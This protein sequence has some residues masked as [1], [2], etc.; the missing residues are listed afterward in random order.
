[1]SSAVAD[2]PRGGPA[3]TALLL[4]VDARGLGGAMLDH[5]LHEQA[6]SFSLLVQRALPDG[7]PLRRVPSSVTPDRLY[8][9]VDLA[10]T[11]STGTLVAERGVLA[12]ADGGVIVV[13]MA[14]RLSVAARTALCEV[15]DYAEVQVARDG[16]GEHHAARICAIVMD[17]SIDDESVHD[18]LRDRLAFVVRMRGSASE[19]LLDDTDELAVASW[20]RQARDAR[21]R[22][23]SVS[24]DD[25]WIAALCE[26]ADAFGI[27]SVRAPL[28][29][30][31]CARAHAALHGR[32]MITEADAEVAAA[33]VLAPRATRLPPPPEEPANDNEQPGEPP[34]SSPPEPPS[35]K[36]G[37]SADAPEP[38]TPPDQQP[39]DADSDESEQNDDA[40]S[41]P[42]SSTDVLREAVTSALPPGMLAQLLEKV[43]GGSMQGRVGAE[44]Q[45]MLRGRPRGSRSGLP[46]GG[47]RLH[48][49][50]TLRAAAPWQR[51]RLKQAAAAALLSATPT[52]KAR[53]RVNIRREDFRIRRYIEKTG[54][55]VLFVVDASG[56]SA[57]NRLAEA[58]GAVEMLLAE[59]YAR[60]DRVSLIAFRGKDTEL[61][62][63][64]TRA[65]ARAKKVLAALPGGG[66]TPLAHAI[67][68]AL[69]QALGAKRAGSAPLVVMLTDGRA[70][71]ARDGTPGRPG[72]ERDALAASARFA[73]QHIPALFVDTSARGEP[74]A[75]RVADAMRARYVLLPA[76]NAKALGGLVRTAMQMAEGSDRA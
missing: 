16:I 65:L 41:P 19:A 18:A 9:G 3:L 69:E 70:N 23:M 53:P 26:T 62:L 73:Q 27:D 76:A 21:H 44:K 40:P 37:E 15:L 28:M 67:E 25:S 49:L 34:P 55:T 54:T 60:R 63:P 1:M 13:P 39:P 64:P 2:L 33:L 75:R 68:A 51:A 42:S 30:L 35:A 43:S 20:E 61:L 46:R 29:A 57:L 50:E 72:A 4:A 48:L 66:G 36:D 5:P 14:E 38:P 12:A 32:L 47:A 45:N 59:S 74:V 31:R 7:A 56:S 58:K 8:G 6:R 10:A 22:V 24:V 71:I 17:E 11:L 52:T